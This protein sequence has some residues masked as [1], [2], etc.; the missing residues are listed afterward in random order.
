MEYKRNTEA[1]SRSH[2]C[3]EKAITITYSVCVPVASVIRNTKR[4]R[5]IVLSSLSFLDVT[6]FSCWE[7]V[8]EH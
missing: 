3:G 8:I 7:K 6:Y 5:R 2:C 4:V 1:R